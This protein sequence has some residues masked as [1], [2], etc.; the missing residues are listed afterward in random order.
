M[1]RQFW[2]GKNLAKRLI[3][4]IHGKK[5]VAD[6]GEENMPGGEI[7]MTP[8]RESVEG[9]IKFE[10]PVIE[11]GK[12]VTDVYLEFK[13]GKV[14]KFDASK[15]KNFL[16]EMLATDKNSSYIGEFGI[17][18]NPKIKKFTKNLLFDEKIA[19]TIHL[20]LGMAYK[21]NGGGNDSAIH[22]DIVKDMR[23]AKIILDGK[24]VQQ[25]GKW[26]L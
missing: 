10:Y 22:W 1:A 13:K 2:I 19:G 12:E 5:A 25:G 4:D 18:L 17:G 16:K 26:R 15:N 7:F 11:S 9:F 3:N 24:V 6:N 14:V 8:V 23:H 21:E 20:A